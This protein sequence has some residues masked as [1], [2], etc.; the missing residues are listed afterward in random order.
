MKS[1]GLK[2]VKEA[3]VTGNWQAAIQRENTQDIP[4]DLKNA[5]RKHKG[6]IAAFR[7]LN[8]SKKKQYLYWLETAKQDKTRKSRINKIVE[9]MSIKTW[10]NHRI[11]YSTL[12][13]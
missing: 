4:S 3:K 7:A 1:S 5:L 10:T 8:Q 13:R 6:A 11:K 9:D 12:E 2:K